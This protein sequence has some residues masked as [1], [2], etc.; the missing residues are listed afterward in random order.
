VALPTGRD[1]SPSTLEKPVFSNIMGNIKDHRVI[2]VLIPAQDG[3]TA[4]L[5]GGRGSS[6]KSLL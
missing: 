1:R 2:C 3:E 6:R 4:D 5:H